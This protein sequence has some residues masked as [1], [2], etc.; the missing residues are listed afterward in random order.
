MK[1]T[2]LIDN[3]VGRSGLQLSYLSHLPG[4]EKE[5]RVA[6]HILSLSNLFLKKNE[7]K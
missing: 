3:G 1:R 2:L 4:V 6:K 5:K 7:A